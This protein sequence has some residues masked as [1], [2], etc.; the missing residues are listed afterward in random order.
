MN[1]VRDLWVV[2]MDVQ[3]DKPC[4]LCS[5]MIQY[6]AEKCYPLSRKSIWTDLCEENERLFQK[7]DGRNVQVD[8]IKRVRGLTVRQ[9][10]DQGEDDERAGKQ[11]FDRK[12]NFMSKRQNFNLDS[13]IKSKLFSICISLIISSHH[14]HIIFFC[15]PTRSLASVRRMPLLFSLVWI[16]V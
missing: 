4:H 10:R 13:T 5:D 3:Y 14:F 2:G 16:I 6:W 8:N 1:N 9:W 11:L 7:I 15:S 12:L